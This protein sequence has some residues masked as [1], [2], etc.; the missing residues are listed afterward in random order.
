MFNFICFLLFTDSDSSGSCDGN[1]CPWSR[2][3]SLSQPLSPS[4]QAN[5][6]LVDLIAEKKCL[7][8]YD[9]QLLVAE[10]YKLREAKVVLTP[11]K[12]KEDGTL[13]VEE[14]GVRYASRLRR[15]ERR[16]SGD[17]RE[18]RMSLNE[19]PVPSPK[20][21]EA[22]LN[23]GL[24]DED[25]TECA[26]S[27]RKERRRSGECLKRRIS[28]KE[29][30]QEMPQFSQEICVSEEA[31]DIPGLRSRIRLVS[32]VGL[33]LDQQSNCSSTDSEVIFN[34]KQ[35]HSK[36]HKKVE[37]HLTYESEISD[38]ETK[39]KIRGIPRDRS[40]HSVKRNLMDNGINRIKSHGGK[41]PR[42][43]TDLRNG[44]TDSQ[45]IKHYGEGLEV[46]PLVLPK[47]KMTKY[48][49]ELIAEAVQKIPKLKIRMKDPNGFIEEMV[50]SSEDE[51][52]PRQQ[53]TSTCENDPENLIIDIPDSPTRLTRAARVTIP[54][55]ELPQSPTSSSK[56][57][58][59]HSSPGVHTARANLIL[60]GP[61]WKKSSHQFAP[62]S[63][64]QLRHLYEI[65]PHPLCQKADKTSPKQINPSD[66]KTLYP[67]DHENTEQ[68]S[69]PV[70]VSNNTQTIKL[71]VKPLDNRTTRK[72]RLIFGQGSMDFQV[73]KNEKG[74]LKKTKPL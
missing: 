52:S 54:G 33:T 9:A 32:A 14:G 70:G 40:V 73:P 29:E 46:P 2:T 61:E 68:L 62:R 45:R 19:E 71:S 38:C 64:S 27:S 7:S 30:V 10:G 12:I 18:R 5:Q 16:R 74:Y 56:I 57:D 6:T 3:R 48:D 4:L 42:K 22:H 20:V 72:V 44:S 26:V 35:L 65:P 31:R 59:Q 51:V 11:H 34:L 41:R 15:E 69:E 60:D 24:L 47:R 66:I 8:K 36:N 67:H 55:S 53:H 25:D 58:S 17:G 39:L 50:T 23:G 63:M 13:A 43:V 1:V 21:E 49:A 37:N 28:V